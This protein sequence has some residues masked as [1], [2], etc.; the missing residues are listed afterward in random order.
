MLRDEGEDVVAREQGRSTVE[1]TLGDVGVGDGDVDA[2]GREH[3]TQFAYAHPVSERCRV[4][5]ELLEKL[6]NAVP[7]LECDLA[8]KNLSHDERREYHCPFR[9]R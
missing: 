8:G 5:R 6:A 7:L 4:Q 1:R 2:F 3:A 9:D